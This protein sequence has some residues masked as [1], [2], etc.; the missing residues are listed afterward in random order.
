MILNIS[1]FN[2]DKI[3]RSGECFRIRETKKGEYLL[4]AFGRLISMRQTEEMAERDEAELRCTEEEFSS[5]WKNYFDLGTDYRAVR[6]GIDPGDVYL[7]EAAEFAKGIR[8]LRQDLWEVMVSFLISQNNNI[9]RIR[10]SVDALCVRFGEELTIPENTDL[11]RPKEKIFSF[12]SPE[13][14]RGVTKEELSGL[15]LGY[16]DEYLAGLILSVNEGRL[17]LQELREAS[18]AE[19][20]KL[21]MSQKGIGNKVADCVC[22]FGLHH[23]EAFP[24][25]THMNHILAEHYREGFPFDRYGANAGILQQYMF[26]SELSGD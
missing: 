2:I 17:D 3:M 1:D 8:I 23:T 12:P 4:P 22:L 18:Y 20:K 9:P 25:D 13:S 15:S 24:L 11:P 5:V 10:R 7:T 19:A 14:L 16:R 21:L 26:F 6:E